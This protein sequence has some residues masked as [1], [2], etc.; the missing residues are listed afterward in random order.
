M[1]FSRAPERRPP[2]EPVRRHQEG[3]RADGAYLCHLYRLPA[4]GLRFF[5]VYGPWGRPDMAL[6]LFTKAILAGEPIDVFNNGQHCARLHLHRRH[7]R[8]RGAH[9]RSRR[10]S[11]TRLERRQARSGHHRCALP[12]LQH[13]QQQPGRAHAL[14]RRAREGAGPRGEEELPA[15]A[16]GR[17]ARAPTPTST[18]SSPTSASSRRRRS[19]SASR[20]SSSGTAAT[21]ADGAG[22]GSPVT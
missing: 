17:R 5:T 7:R 15:D 9:R 3:E 16:A 2:G 8:G 21:I 20:A 12:A 14:H 4:T 6:F 18:R 11:R 13:R 22:C 1:P 10:R 19:R